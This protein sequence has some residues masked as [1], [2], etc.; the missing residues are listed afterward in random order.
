MIKRFYC[1]INNIFSNVKK[2]EKY[3]SLYNEMN[4]IKKELNLKIISHN[5]IVKILDVGGGVASF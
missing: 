3:H 4:E 2:F 5:K 1:K